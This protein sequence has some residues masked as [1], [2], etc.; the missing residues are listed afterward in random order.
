MIIDWY[1]YSQVRSLCHE[2]P[3]A[4]EYLTGIDP[5]LP[6]I[7][8]EDKEP[9]ASIWMR[10]IVVAIRHLDALLTQVKE[11]SDEMCKILW[12]TVPAVRLSVVEKIQ[13][14]LGRRGGGWAERD[15]WMEEVDGGLVRRMGLV[16]KWEKWRS[17]TFLWHIRSHLWLF[18]RTLDTVDAER[19]QSEADSL[20]RRRRVWTYKEV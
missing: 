3:T 6:C 16:R 15:D 2:L 9:L 8:S 4:P 1:P 11:E 13:V 14:R 5:P 12:G 19:W 17:Q 20:V 18:D 7:I 10:C